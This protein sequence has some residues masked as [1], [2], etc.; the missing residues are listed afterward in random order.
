MIKKLFYLYAIMCSS[1]Y[2]QTV[3]L[4]ITEKNNIQYFSINDFIYK[5]NLKSTYYQTK[6]KLEILYEDNKIYFS[7]HSSYCRINEN[8]YHMIYK[9]LLI[10]NTLFIPVV[11]F[12]NII[13]KAKL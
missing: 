12:Q 10:N 13:T 3:S 2:S 9:S 4:D 7:P 5:N 8:S 1:I 6:E 11:T